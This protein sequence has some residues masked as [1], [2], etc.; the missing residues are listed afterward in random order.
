MDLTGAWWGR[1]RYPTGR[2]VA[3]WATITDSDG[4][5][6][7]ATSEA[8]SIGTTTDL[9]HAD[10]RG[11]KDGMSV[12]FTKAYD[13]ASDAAH[14]VDYTGTLELSGERITGEW[15]LAEAR[16]GFEM[17]RTLPD[18]DEEAVERREIVD[19]RT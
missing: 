5:F 15:R 1:Y 8:N 11:R 16:G 3:F 7:G 18:A 6:T 13:G 10:L 19:A 14:A 17:H 2:A 4:I 12:T 9:L